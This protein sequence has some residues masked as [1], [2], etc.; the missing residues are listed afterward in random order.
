M[1]NYFSYG[2]LEDEQWQSKQMRFKYLVNQ[3]IKKNNWILKEHI[4]YKPLFFQ[5]V[6]KKRKR[7]KR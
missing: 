7:R 2:Y 4:E 6:L 3:D 1:G 5:K